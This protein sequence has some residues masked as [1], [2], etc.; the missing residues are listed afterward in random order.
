MFGKYKDLE[1]SE[2]LFAFDV[3]GSGMLVETS[4]MAE[5]D[6]PEQH[7]W[8]ALSYVWGGNVPLK[9]TKAT[10]LAHKKG[11]TVDIFPRTMKDAALVCRGL[12]IRYLWIDALCIIQDDQDDLHEQL[13]HMPEV[14]QYATLTISATS[15]ASSRDG[16]F[17]RRGYRSK[18]FPAINARVMT[19][20]GEGIILFPYMD[21]DYGI[22]GA[23][24]P[25]IEPIIRRAWT[26]Q[27]A[28][29]LSSTVSWA[30]V[31]HEYTSR[32]LSSAS[33]RLR[34]LSAIARVFQLETGNRYLAGLWKEDI[35]A[36]LCWGNGTA[37][38]T[39]NDPDPAYK[40]I[41]PR[42]KE[43]RAPSWSWASID[44]PVFYWPHEAYT[45][46]R[47][48]ELRVL[49]AGVTPMYPNGEFDSVASAFLTIRGPVCP[50]PLDEPVK[51][52]E[53]RTENPT[54]LFDHLW[55]EELYAYVFP[56]ALEDSDEIVNTFWFLLLA[57]QD[58]ST[59]PDA[60]FRQP[61]TKFYGLVL[62]ESKEHSGTY[63]R[64]GYFWTGDLFYPDAEW[65]HRPK[66]NSPFTP[67]TYL[68]NFEDKVITLI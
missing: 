27:E 59:T 36:A 1:D 35:P 24:Q 50:V 26:Y 12:G 30:D 23:S 11:I 2:M 17:S 42:P 34:A 28:M 33:D 56:D 45:P 47:I 46:F 54:S 64:F 63:S 55:S 32:E 37:P 67:A 41:S 25:R 48:L 9:T 51:L 18:G 65:R 38:G 31:V 16:F 53:I 8:C 15:S 58:R 21:G 29:L 5:M 49:S 44:T 60:F 66:V 57:E 10:L 6:K 19:D 61:T 4:E 14:F 39:R 40:K 3:D 52:R 62:R 68:D 13:S 7:G 22:S 20:S 43:Y